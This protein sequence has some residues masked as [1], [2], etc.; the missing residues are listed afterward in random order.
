MEGIY[1]QNTGNVFHSLYDEMKAEL[2]LLA[3]LAPLVVGSN[4]PLPPKRV[5]PSSPR[6][7][8][9]TSSSLPPAPTSPRRGSKQPLTMQQHVRLVLFV[10]NSLLDVIAQPTT[11]ASGVNAC[12]GMVLAVCNAAY[13]GIL[14]PIAISS[15]ANTMAALME[16]QVQ[17]KNLWRDFSR[18]ID[19]ES[20]LRS[21]ATLEG[22]AAHIAHSFLLQ[23]LISLGPGCG[24]AADMLCPGIPQLLN[25]WLNEAL[26]GGD[27][28]RSEE[29]LLVAVSKFPT[30]EIGN[31][32]PETVQSF[33]LLPVQKA[34]EFYA[35]QGYF[36]LAIELSKL[37]VAVAQ[38]FPM[39]LSKS[40]AILMLCPN[41]F[42][43]ICT[44]FISSLPWSVASEED[45]E[46]GFCFVFFFFPLKFVFF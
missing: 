27:K 30:R 22:E 13:S 11:S 16:Q 23:R 34:L 9:N 14:K 37:L 8:H 1:L 28:V 6:L 39:L 35:E 4:I 24:W 43:P 2:E 44:S 15:D 10:V 25:R 46:V 29:V 7:K 40:L 36:R 32:T 19:V 45:L 26:L 3:T 31:L 12:K 18:W 21:S 20:A 42:L 17:V 38:Y 41:K 5:A 33:V